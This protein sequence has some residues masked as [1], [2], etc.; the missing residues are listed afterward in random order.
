MWTGKPSPAGRNTGN[1]FSRLCWANWPVTESPRPSVVQP[2]PAPS[3]SLVQFRAALALLWGKSWAKPWGPPGKGLST[4][5]RCCRAEGA[6]RG[7]KPSSQQGPG[8]R[9]VLGDF[10]RGE[11]DAAPPGKRSPLP[12]AKP[13][14]QPLP[15]PSLT[16]TIQ[17]SHSSIPQ[18][19]E[20]EGQL[21]APGWCGLCHLTSTDSSGHS[22][23]PNVPVVLLSLRVCVPAPCG[24]FPASVGNSQGCRQREAT[25]DFCVFPSH[26][27]WWCLLNRLNL[28][29]S[30]KINSWNC[31]EEEKGFWGALLRKQVGVFYAEGGEA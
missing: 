11:I 18:R 15:T 3:L 8:V 16:C 5:W 27:L 28:D 20:E 13:L 1:G 7:P 17:A 23:D 29:P 14:E 21:K 24:L 19:R 12:A 22:G 25:A 10:S 26:Q 6:P 9:Q 31:W 4:G 2:V 30:P